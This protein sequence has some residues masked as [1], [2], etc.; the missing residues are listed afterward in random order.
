[1][2]SVRPAEPFRRRTK[3][4]SPSG[5]A[6]AKTEALRVPPLCR[7]NRPERRH[8]AAGDPGSPFT[9]TLT[10]G[11]AAAV[12]VAHLPPAK[13]H[14]V[15]GPRGEPPAWH[16][17][18]RH[19]AA[20][21]HRRWN[22]ITAAAS[23]PHHEDRGLRSPCPCGEWWAWRLHHKLMHRPTAVTRPP[24]APKRSNFVETPI[25]V[26]RDGAPR[27]RPGPT[28]DVRIRARRLPITRYRPARPGC[29]GRWRRTCRCT[30]GWGFP[31]AD[32]GT[33]T[34]CSRARS[35]PWW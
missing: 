24:A 17:H 1:M 31:R 32:R 11:P 15:H 35:S 6:P 27:R 7:S 20:R 26:R 8:V 12:G 29:G 18:H 19:Q 22:S 3:A 5:K 28:P 23:W 33:S 14:S 10:S 13:D 21:A 34:A 2:R 4:R 9:T 16:R 25:R 30:S